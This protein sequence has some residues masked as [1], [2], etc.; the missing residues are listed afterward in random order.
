MAIPK[1]VDK[2][3]RIQRANSLIQ[4]LLGQILPDYL[5]KSQGL[6]SVSRVETSSDLRWAKVWLSVINAEDDDILQLLQKNIYHI[7]GELNRRIPMKIVPRLQFF[8]DTSARFAQHL[9]E[10][11][12]HLHDND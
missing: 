7:Q 3:I 2:S 10:V 11:F 4:E 5:D 1:K 12:T 9:N 8:I 6:V